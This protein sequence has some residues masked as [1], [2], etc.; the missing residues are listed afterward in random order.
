MK[1]YSLGFIF[2]SNRLRDALNSQGFLG[3]RYDVCM[4]NPF[5]PA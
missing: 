3:E 5:A 4:F 2:R 1:I